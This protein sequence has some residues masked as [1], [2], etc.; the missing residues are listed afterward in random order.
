M[1]KKMNYSTGSR[2]RFRQSGYE[3]KHKR[4][5]KGSRNKV[6]HRGDKVSNVKNNLDFYGDPSLD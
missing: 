1:Y 5:W 6:T 4:E 2:K 3:N